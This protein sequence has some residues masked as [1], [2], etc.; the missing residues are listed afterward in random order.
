M[1]LTTRRLTLTEDPSTDTVE[2]VATCRVVLTAPE[3]ASFALGN[4]FTLRCAIRA[5]DPGQG[6][7]E[8]LFQYPRSKTFSGLVDLL[9]VDQVFT[10]VV[11]RDLL[12]EDANANNSDEMRAR[13]RLRDNSTGR[14]RQ[15][16]SAIRALDE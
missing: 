4:S 8:I 6:S 15:R 2:C 9:D 5:N 13:F 12:D 14:V 11:S 7:D 10:V 1:D 16:L 3:I